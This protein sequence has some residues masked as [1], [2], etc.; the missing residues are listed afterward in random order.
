[1]ALSNLIQRDVYFL[2]KGDTITVLVNE[3]LA[4]NGWA[5]GHY[6]SYT[7]SMVVDGHVVPV[8]RRGNGIQRGPFAMYGSD[9][10]EDQSMAYTGQHLKYKYA[11]TVY[12]NTHFL[13]RVFETNSYFDRTALNT[14]DDHYSN[15][16]SVIN[17]TSFSLEY[18]AGNPLY[19]SERGF[20][21]TEQITE[22]HEVVAYIF[23]EPKQENS[24]FLGVSNIS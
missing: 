7:D 6:F 13:T 18:K 5:G 16:F 3:E 9:E 24:F 4:E 15:S 2:K 19:V 14:M 8:V 20:L 10:P 11:Q 12:G 17:P 23:Q 22:S 21:T 1:M